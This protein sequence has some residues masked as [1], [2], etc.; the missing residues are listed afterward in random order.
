M[1][2]LVISKTTTLEWIGIWHWN[3]YITK[4]L[5]RG[6]STPCFRVT[7]ITPQKYRRLD[8]PILWGSSSFNVKKFINWEKKQTKKT[9]FDLT[10]LSY[11]YTGMHI[12]E[13]NTNMILSYED[14]AS[15]AQGITKLTMKFPFA[16]LAL[17]FNNIF[18]SSYF[19]FNIFLVPTGR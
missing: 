19:F 14:D 8:S 12:N 7:A 15:D 13:Y 9:H 4:G 17:I 5:Y 3:W 16:I 11:C 18:F 10:K 2:N 1:R 6:I